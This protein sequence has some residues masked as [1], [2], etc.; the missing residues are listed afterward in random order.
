MK[1]LINKTKMT[2]LGLFILSA[3]VSHA[4]N[5]GSTVKV[6]IPFEFRVGAT[7]VPP[8]QYSLVQREQHLVTLRDARGQVVASAL[9]VGI[10]SSAPAEDSKLSFYVSGGQH[11]LT[12]AWVEGELRGE[13]LYAPTADPSATAKRRSIQPAANVAR[14]P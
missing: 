3:V 11:V 13:R 12:E 7:L 6:N 4:Q 8:G 9:T 1:Q 10:E 2:L 5:V 14:Q